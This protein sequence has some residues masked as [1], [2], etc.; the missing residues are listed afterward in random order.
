M[1]L[2]RVNHSPPQKKIELDRRWRGEKKKEKEKSTG[3]RGG[4]GA[5]GR[6]ACQRPTLSC[7]RPAAAAGAHGR[8]RPTGR[9]SH[10]GG[11]WMEKKKVAREEAKG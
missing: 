1:C 2:L 10:V 5:A 3:S 11:R 9:E 8:D 4:S 7:G 6:G